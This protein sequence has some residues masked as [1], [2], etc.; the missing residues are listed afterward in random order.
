[1]KFCLD[2]CQVGGGQLEGAGPEVETV[3]LVCSLVINSKKA[4]CC[5]LNLLN[6]SAAIITHSM[7]LHLMSINEKPFPVAKVSHTCF[8][9]LDIIR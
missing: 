3:C 1:M 2:D 5:L 6:P 9:L 4:G 7:D 8:V